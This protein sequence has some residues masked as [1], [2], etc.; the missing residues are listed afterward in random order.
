MQAKEKIILAL[1]VDH[2]EKALDLVS[3]LKDHVG[4]FKVGMELYYSTGPEIVNRINE[5]GGKV[6]VDL[7]FKAT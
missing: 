6:F 4:M 1:D 7:T 2:Q 5:L 3:E